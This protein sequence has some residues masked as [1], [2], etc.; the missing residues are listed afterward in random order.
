MKFDI[1]GKF[2]V[3]TAFQITGR[4]LFLVGEL[5]SGTVKVGDYINL[6]MI[7]STLVPNISAVELVLRYEENEAVEDLAIGVKELDDIVLSKVQDSISLLQT[8][9]ILSND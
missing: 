5:K 7:D 4:G 2:K 9:S 1:V 3:F 8:I 6:T